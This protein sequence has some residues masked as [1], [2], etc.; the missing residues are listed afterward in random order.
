MRVK[1]ERFEKCKVC[2]KKWNISIFQEIPDTGYICKDCSNKMKRIKE[3]YNVQ[4]K[5]NQ[6][7]KQKA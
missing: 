5:S 6:K 7:T 3:R 4:S 1:G 2:E